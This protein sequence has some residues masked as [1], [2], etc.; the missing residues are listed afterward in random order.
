M[1]GL[2][3]EIL[4]LKFA[5]AALAL[6]SLTALADEATMLA[7]SGKITALTTN[8]PRLIT[9][10]VK[11]AGG[12]TN[13]IFTVTDNTKFTTS[14]IG[15]YGELKR[16]DNLQI[17]YKERDGGTNEADRITVQNAATTPATT[18][19][20]PAANKPAPKPAAKKAPPKKKNAPI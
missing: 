9:A 4:N 12:T 16:G 6:A 15:V 2:K 13:L 3:S 5:A 20:K 1:N 11:T 10:T 19:P 17:E 18:P 14:G 7:C 8:T